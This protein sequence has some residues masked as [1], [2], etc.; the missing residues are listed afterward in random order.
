V[1]RRQKKEIPEEIK[2][3]I[4]EMIMG[5]RNLGKVIEN[6]E[7][8]KSRIGSEGVKAY[9]LANGGRAEFKGGGMDMGAGSS[10]SSKSSG[11]AGGASSGGNYGGNNFKSDPDDN[12]EQYGAQGQYSRPPSTPSDVVI[13]EN[14]ME[15][16]VNTK[17]L[18]YLILKV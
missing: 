12:R 15:H 10:K 9:G 16:R 11:P 5:T 4:F 6:S 14:N 18:N 8:T 13:I 3:K 1:F 17:D 7:R 2:K